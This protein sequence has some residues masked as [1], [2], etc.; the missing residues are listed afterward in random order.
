M[1]TS[2]V[3]AIVEA[4]IDRLMTAVGVPHWRLTIAYERH[5]TG[6]MGTCDL[7]DI[8]YCRAHITID[9]AQHETPDEVINT[10]V[11]ELLHIILAPAELYR[12]VAIQNLPES[13]MGAN[14]VVYTHALEQMVLS[15]ERGL[16]KHLR[17]LPEPEPA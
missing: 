10:L 12:N 11:H 15:L 14:E 3:Q 2:E 16:A 5:E 1:D 9:P 8:D 4:N 13:A 7:A 6:A 17:T